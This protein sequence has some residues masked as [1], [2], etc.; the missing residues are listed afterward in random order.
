L[1]R[2]STIFVEPGL[3]W[4]ENDTLALPSTTMKWFEKDLVK[5]R[6]YNNDTGEVTLW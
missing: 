6:A 4:A 2:A 5:I 1:A 3:S